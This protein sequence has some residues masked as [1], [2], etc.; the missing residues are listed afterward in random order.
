MPEVLTLFADYSQLH[1]LD[2]KSESPVG[3][4]WTDAALADRVAVVRD[5]LAVRTEVD[6]DVRVEVEVLD[7]APADDSDE[8]DHVVLV[9]IA[10]P[11]GSLVVMG[12]SDFLPDADKFAVPA[13]W[14]T[15][16]VSKWNLAAAIEAGMDAGE[17]DE[18]IEKIRLL[19]WPSDATS[20]TV[21]V[22]KR[23]AD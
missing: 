9:T 2:E 12:N 5:A 23:W 20:N 3:E 17:S 15:V 18:T 19:V 11:S 1:I 13:G 4:D 10:V 21:T 22:R 6:V 8:F 16:E 14:V 7:A